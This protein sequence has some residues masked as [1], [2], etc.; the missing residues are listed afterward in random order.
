MAA[1]AWN[2]GNACCAVPGVFAFGGMWS[3]EGMSVP[4]RQRFG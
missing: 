4:F 2:L 3:D 1:A